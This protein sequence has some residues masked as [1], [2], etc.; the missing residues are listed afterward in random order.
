MDPDLSAIVQGE[1]MSVAKNLI[2]C[3]LHRTIGSKV[4]T[5]I[6]VE[7]E[8][9]LSSHDP[10]CHASRGK[11]RRNSTMFG[12]AGRAYVYLIY[13]LHYCLNLVT[14]Q[15]GKGEA[16]LI[17]ALEPLK[18]QDIMVKNRGKINKDNLT[19]GP[20]KLC[21]AFKIDGNL[22]GH[23]LSSQPLFISVPKEYQHGIT[24]KETPRIG[25][26]KGK[27]MLLRYVMADSSY[28]SRSD[29]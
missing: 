6:I 3:H 21:Q 17:R 15:V 29:S 8:A 13:G 23:D 26:T 16:V 1:C 22:N 14:G 28:L 25:I 4:L 10:A 20:G 18:G 19:N 7:T 12:Q 5:G 24:I 2:G 9:Y 11:T 27:D